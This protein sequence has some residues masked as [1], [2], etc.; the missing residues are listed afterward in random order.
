LG[1]EAG[2]RKPGSIFNI[3]LI[4]YREKL[5]LY[6]AKIR[7]DEIQVKNLDGLAFSSWIRSICENGFSQRLLFKTMPW[8]KIGFS[9]IPEAIRKVF[10][11]L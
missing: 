2:G 11:S 8:G 10:L 1:F 3:N 4:F 9:E 6:S 5:W 7:Q